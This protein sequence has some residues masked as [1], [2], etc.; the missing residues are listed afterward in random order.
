MQ[1]AAHGQAGVRMT[2]GGF[3]GCVVALGRQSVLPALARAVEKE[4]HARTGCTPTLI[5]ALP[6]DGAFVQPPLTVNTA[7]V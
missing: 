6:S 1:D 7:A 4:Y 3:G 5:P 2:G